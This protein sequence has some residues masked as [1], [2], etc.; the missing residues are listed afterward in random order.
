MEDEGHIVADLS[1]LE[2][3]LHRSIQ[4][5]L[6]AFGKTNEES[7]FELK[8]AHLLTVIVSGTSL[9]LYGL[10]SDPM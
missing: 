6:D 9:S 5:R 2:F 3:Y 1:I 8:Q 4:L 10:H 7:Q